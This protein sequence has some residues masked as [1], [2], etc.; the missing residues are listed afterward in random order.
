MI[1]DC[2][3]DKSTEELDACFKEPEVTLSLPVWFLLRYGLGMCLLMAFRY[4]LYVCILQKEMQSGYVCYDDRGRQIFVKISKRLST[5]YGFCHL[6]LLRR[7]NWINENK[8]DVCYEIS[9]R[10]T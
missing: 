4:Y 9:D 2:K 5:R 7:L 10:V 6:W 8:T 1:H 3:E